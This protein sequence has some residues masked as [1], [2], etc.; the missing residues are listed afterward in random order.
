MTQDRL[1]CDEF[2]MTHEFVA[3]V[4]GV[5]RPTITLIFGQLLRS[6]IVE[7]RRGSITITD[8]IALERAAC[9]CYDQISRNYQR[10]LP[11]M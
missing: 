1:G 5:R 2:P 8:R 11:Q 7:Y 4:L 9:E 6:G 10:L 3:S